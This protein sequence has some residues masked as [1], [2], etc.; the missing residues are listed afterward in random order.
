MNAMPRLRRLAYWLLRAGLG[1]FVLWQFVFLLGLNL[2]QVGHHYVDNVTGVGEAFPSLAAEDAAARQDPAKFEQ[3]TTRWTELTGQEQSWELFAPDVWYDIPF[4][5][6]EFRWQATPDGA[7][8]AAGLIAALAASQQLQTAS[9]WLAAAP[10]APV[11]L[12]SDNEPR[13]IHHYFRVGK[14]RLRRLEGHL[15]LDF[16]VPPD[17][18]AED[19]KDQWRQRVFERVR[20]QAA[21]MRA[22]LEWR[23]TRYHLQHPDRDTPKQIILY[24]RLYRVPP[25]GAS[26]WTWEGPEVR[27]IARWRPHV[28]YV[29]GRPQVEVYD[30]IAG[31]FDVME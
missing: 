5:A 3:I 6:V 10:P 23:W 18:S 30:L 25:P 31:R 1:L 19:M 17:K 21:V 13:D 9:A 20:A 2:C 24:V 27:P 28:R 12:L 26:P 16:Y 15:D 7:R 8:S 29:P 11:Y 14:F 4:V 22:Y